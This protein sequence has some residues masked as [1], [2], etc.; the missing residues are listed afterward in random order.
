VAGDPSQILI[1]RRNR[2]I[3]LPYHEGLASLAGGVRV[4][5]AVVVPHTHEVVRL[6]RNLGLKA[7]APIISRYDW[8]GDKPFRTQ[9][10]T[11]AV[12][13]MNRRAYVLS[14]MGTGKTRSTLYAIDFL[15]REGEIERAIVVAPLSTLTTVW[16]A[17]VFRYFNHL[18]VGVLHGTKDRRLAVLSQ[19]HH[20]YVIN[21]DGIKTI[22]PDLLLRRDIQCVAIDELA[23]FRNARTT[24]W[25]CLSSLVGNRKYAWGLTGAPAPNE[26]ADAWAQVKLLTPERVPKFFKTFKEATMAQVSTFRWVPRPNHKEVVYSTMQPAVRFTRDE[27]VELPPTIYATRECDLS[28]PQ[29]KA[30]K[31]MMTQL[32][33][34]FAAGEVSAANEGVLMSKLLQITSGFV[35]LKDRAPVEL[36]NAPRMD[37]LRELLD[38]AEGK[39]IVFADFI[40]A[41]K[42]IARKLTL[43]GYS[44]EQ[45][46]G[47]TSKTERDGIFRRFQHAEAP[48]I[49]VAH[50]KCMSHGLTLTAAS[51]IVWFSPTTSLETYE[52]ACAR[53]TRPG[54]TR[55][56]LIMHLTG[57]Q[58]ESKLY[59]R[60]Q[61]KAS[62]QGALL[63]LFE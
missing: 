56:T 52:Q 28:P 22:L 60:L 44:V 13:T 49:L 31:A 63:E 9:K 10:I 26:P 12:L 30:Y 14:E 57:S 20:I 42:M 29:A 37:A 19:P 17:E 18:S 5:D 24:R 15:I 34:S 2:T 23:A 7:P 6:A 48:R 8:N 35:Y 50:P 55:K 16:D 45:V 11:A 41:S 54:Q 27:C 62:L 21:H 43:D 32:K 61:Q 4:G 58:V 36:D 40:H 53:I 38:E 46:S 59:K 47:E 51:V 33:L 39:V 3:R 1:D 25:K